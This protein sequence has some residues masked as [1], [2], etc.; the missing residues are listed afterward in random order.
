MR[1]S[2]VDVRRCASRGRHT[3]LVRDFSFERFK[4]FDLRRFTQ[5][6]RSLRGLYAIHA[7]IIRKSYAD[8]RGFCVMHTRFSGFPRS[9]HVCPRM[10]NGPFT[11]VSLMFHVYIAY[12]AIHSCFLRDLYAIYA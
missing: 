11:H 2:F 7:E 8:V 1:Y 6:M 5:F 9:F 4:T 12:M 3:W 10:F